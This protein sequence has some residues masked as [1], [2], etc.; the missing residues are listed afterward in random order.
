MKRETYEDILELTF[1]QRDYEKVQHVAHL[2][3]VTFDE[4]VELVLI[5]AIED[6]A[7][8]S[9]RTIVSRIR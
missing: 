3:S 7:D 1:S 5:D 8:K 4:A 2:H 6:L 9:D